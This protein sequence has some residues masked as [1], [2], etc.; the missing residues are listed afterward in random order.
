MKASVAIATVD[1]VAMRSP[2]MISGTESGSSTF[3]KS[4]FGVIPIPRPAS[5]APSGTLLRP[6]TMLR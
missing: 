6:V 3:Q 2:A 5:L 4:W 1:T